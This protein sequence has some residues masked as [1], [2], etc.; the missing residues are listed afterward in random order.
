MQARNRG[1]TNEH[2]RGY[3]KRILNTLAI[4]DIII[5]HYLRLM[6]VEEILIT[7]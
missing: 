6:K 5:P 3:L 4:Q 1:Y 2:G 7:L